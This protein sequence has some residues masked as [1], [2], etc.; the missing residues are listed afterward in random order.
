MKNVLLEQTVTFVKYLLLVLAVYLLWRGHNEPGGGFIAGI[1]ASIGH[2]FYAIVYG[3]KVTRRKM[4]ASPYT[5]IGMGLLTS[6]CSAFIPMFQ[7]KAPLT[8]LWVEI[9][10]VAMGTP[11]LFDIGVFMVVFG[12]ITAIILT[13]IEVLEWN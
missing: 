2:V 13:I 7:N 6:V 12:M 10:G 3:S 8:G 1:M 9:G 5:F 4:I 11:L